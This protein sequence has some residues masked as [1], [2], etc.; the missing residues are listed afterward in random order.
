MK[1]LIL[2]YSRTGTTKKVAERLASVLGADIENV[3]DN[4]NRS[5]IRGYMISGRD[6]VKKTL[7]KI[8]PLTHNISDYDL[9]IIGTPVWAWTMSAPIKSLITELKDN[10]KQVAFFCT[11]GGEGNQGAISNMIKLSGKEPLASLSLLN[12]KV[13]KDQIEKE[14]NDFVSKLK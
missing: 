11:Q 3:V 4:V 8:N 13:V 14:I 10:L 5:G 7:I 9:V 12:K 1:T 6:A 2:Y